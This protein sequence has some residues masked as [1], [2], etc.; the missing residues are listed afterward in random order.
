LPEDPTSAEGFDSGEC[1]S[2]GALGSPES[3]DW[4]PLVAFVHIPRTGGG[5]VTS[6]ISRAYGRA[7]SSGNVQKNADKSHR[8][9]QR[10]AE[11]PD[12]WSG[13]ALADHVPY[14]LYARYLPPD[15]RY[16]TFLRDPVERVLSHYYFHAQAGPEKVRMIWRRE[17]AEVA[18]E[19]DVSL[20]AGLARGITIYNNF[21]TRFL[22]GGESLD[23]E[24]PPNALERAKENLGR[25]AL[26]G[27]T[28]RLDEGVIMLDRMLGV[29]P[30]GYHLRHVREGRPG[31]DDVHADLRRLIEEHNAL[32]TE[33]YRIAQQRF[34]VEAAAAGD[35]SPQ[36]EELRRERAMVTQQAETE[37]LASK[38]A[39]RAR[40]E[41]ARR[42]RSEPA[43]D[44]PHVELGLDEL[45]EQLSM[46]ERRLQAIE[47]ALGTVG[48][49]PQPGKK[50]AARRAGA[51][52]P[53][54]ARK[55]QASASLTDSGAPGAS[56]PTST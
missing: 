10:I 46:L 54:K 55:R 45:R 29:P 36:V 26:V 11:N 7:K 34:D 25:F 43:T 3:S 6:A 30:A 16:I 8:L 32:D 47:S 40:R 41:A 17:G 53:K 20:E 1:A 18:D 14:G 35:M 51:E 52:R 27:V 4:K 22:W 15:T 23:G 2:F 19:D 49:A 44:G 9:F 39:G 33:L 37:R 42:G 50:R 12:A 28:E 38:T 13:R 31:A 48:E 24:L 56:E 21:A 5:S